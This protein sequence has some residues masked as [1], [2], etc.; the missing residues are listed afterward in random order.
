MTDLNSAPRS[1]PANDI[2]GLAQHVP[3]LDPGRYLDE[4]AR[5]A[6]E[7]ALA[8]WPA[9]ARLIGLVGPSEGHAAPRA[10]SGESKEGGEGKPR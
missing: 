5:L 1:A 10:Y 9:L 3:E 2:I 8:K 4:Q 6:Y 7:D